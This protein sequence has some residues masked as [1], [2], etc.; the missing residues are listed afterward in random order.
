MKTLFTYFSKSG[1]EHVNGSRMDRKRFENGAIKVDK[2]F[3]SILFLLFLGVGQ[4]WGT[5]VTYTQ[6]STTAISK[7][8]GTVPTGSSVSFSTTYTDKN[9]LTATN[10]QTFTLS[11]CGNIAITNITLSMRSNSDS[12]AGKLYYSVDGG[13]TW[14]YLAGSSSLGSKFNTSEWYGSWSTSYVNVSK[15][16]GIVTSSS[17]TNGF[18]LKI[19]ATAKSIYCQSFTLTYNTDKYTVS[20][21]GGTGTADKASDTQTTVGGALTLPSATPPSDCADKGWTFAGWKKTS[22]VSSVTTHEPTLY[23]AGSSYYP[24]ATETLYAVYQLSTE[25]TNCTSGKIT[26]T[27]GLSVGER[28]ILISES[29]TAQYNGL[30]GNTYGTQKSYST[31]P[32]SIHLLDVEEG[33]SSGQVAFYD[34]TDKNYLA[35]TSDG[36]ALHSKTSIDAYSSWTVAISSGT[37]TITNAQ[38]TSRYIQFNSGS[39]P[40]RF[41][42]YTSNQ[43]AVQL[44]KDCSPIVTY[45]SN[46]DCTTDYFIDIMHDNETI[47]KQGSYS[48]P[49]ALSDASK[50]EDTHCDEKHYHFI[51][52]VESSYIDEDGTL[53]DGYTIYP[54]GDS[55]HTAANKTFYAIWAKED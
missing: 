12:G 11:S 51:G 43:T 24:G 33:N 36:N 14:T 44:Y 4:A 45:L 48:M 47:E 50:G 25:R 23:A 19:E 20:Y 1:S 5:T 53:K 28:V 2:L 29:N 32:A 42:C 7:S 9:Q 17:V 40:K 49:A 41:A 18:I 38:Y 10:I 34:R 27:A 46:P 3:A 54:A 30:D 21:D 31:T 8:S 6:S 22:G 13:T 39:N 15:D 35:L 52:W 37:A 16:V 55:G 26:S